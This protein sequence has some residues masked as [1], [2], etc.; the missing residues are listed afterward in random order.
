MHNGRRVRE[1][2]TYSGPVETNATTL[3]CMRCRPPLDHSWPEQKGLPSSI[4]ADKANLF[5]VC[6]VAFCMGHF[7]VDM[8]LIIHRYFTCTGM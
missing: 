3:A 2:A 6:P 7:Q 8:C 5:P 1:K 4:A